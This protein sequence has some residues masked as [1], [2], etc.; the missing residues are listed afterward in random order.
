[1]K[2]IS[3]L[4]I[5]WILVCYV[6]EVVAI[7]Q[8]KVLIMVS[9]TLDMGDPEKHDAR[10]NLWEVAPPH[11]VFMSHGYSVD[12]VSPN[13][14]KAEFMM[15]P[16][17][18]SSYTI[19]YEGF[20]DKTQRTLKPKQL[21]LSQYWGVFIG[22]GYG[23]L[24]DIANNKSM[25]TIIAAVYQAG[26]IIGSSGHGAGAF[27]NVILP[28]G[29]Y[30][31]QG[32]KVAG[33]P[34]STEKSKSWAKQGT[35]L[36]FLVESQLNKNGAKAQNKELLVDKHEVIVDQRIVST[37]FLPSAALVAKEMIRLR[38]LGSKH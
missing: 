27:A 38:E 37:M 7:E 13:G 14:G 11:H 26:G 9:N 6:G 10:N 3:G 5:A 24:F 1:M 8:K 28:S 31:V 18:I 22:G 21:D 12:F 33:F 34:D 19:K 36:P 35:L 23:P 15:N 30:L 2:T 32:K 25:Q 17:G 29:A 16:V 20:A 4:L